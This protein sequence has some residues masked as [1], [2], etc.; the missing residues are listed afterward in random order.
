MVYTGSKQKFDGYLRIY[1]NI[2]EDE[3]TK[4]LPE[5]VEGEELRFVDVNSEQNFTQPPSRFTEASLVRDLEEKNIG[6]PSTYAPIVAT[7]T[8]RKYVVRE[9][10]S[11][12]PT[13]L[14]FVVTELMEG[15]FKEIADAHF[16]ASMEDKLDDVEVKDLNWKS[17]VSS[18]YDIL[19]EEL[20]YADKSIEKVQIEDELTD[21]VCEVCGKQMAIKHGRFGDFLACSGYPEC[22][23]TKPIVKK[24]DVNC[25]VCGKD[26]VARKSKK[27]KVFYGCSR[28][29]DCNQLYWYK[30]VNKKCPK[31]GEILLEKKTK[32]TKLAC[33]NSECDYK[34]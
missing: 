23:T 25:P 20:E 22:K 2:N 17:V 9:K 16:T 1:N 10:K 15:Y 28:Y 29:P 6:R 5:L 4:A 3:D 21:E 26:I 8:E 12:K 13:D 30:P 32:S 7:L 11:L 18:F 14:G 27:G 19:K 33:S 31:C 24:T 34:E